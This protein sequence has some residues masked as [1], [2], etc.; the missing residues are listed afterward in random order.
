MNFLL[1]SR[2]AKH[3]IY[4]R[5]GMEMSADEVFIKLQEE[6]PDDERQEIKKFLQSI[7]Y[8]PNKTISPSNNLALSND[9]IIVA[10]NRGYEFVLELNSVNLSGKVLF[11]HP[12]GWHDYKPSAEEIRLIIKAKRKWEM[13]YK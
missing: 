12:M 5:L 8:N 4:S 1:P 7:G 6:I 11:R 2:K 3:V 10:P 9:K 13:I